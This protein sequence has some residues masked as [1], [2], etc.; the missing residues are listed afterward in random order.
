[1]SKRWF[2]L[3]SIVVLFTLFIGACGSETRDE[4]EVV[5]FAAAS[6]RDAMQAIG[7]G[8]EE[9]TGVRV[10]FNFA[11][12]NVLAQ[13]IV[14][15]SGADVFLSANVRWMDAVAE[16]GRVMEGTRRVL[17][18]NTLAVV[19][20]P[21]S[22]WRLD[23]PCRLAEFGFKYLALGDPAAVPA[24]RYARDWLS[25]QTCDGRSLWQAVEDRVAPA[26]NVRAALGLV[27]AEPD[28]V[29]IVY[30][31]DYLAFAQEARLLYEV[32]AAAGPPIRYTLAQVDA[33]PNPEAARRFL[34]YLNGETARRHFEPHGFTV[35]KNSEN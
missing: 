33:G 23:A 7:A 26:P 28:L 14:A 27:L 20:H 18:T 3:A 9:E 30:K 10:V 31:T 34:G 12:S 11:G 15:A 16:A 8:F 17:L 21:R 32:P 5:V 29:G 2:V 24:G 4:E 22:T 1:M 25:A 35:L 19:A 6:L 13:Q